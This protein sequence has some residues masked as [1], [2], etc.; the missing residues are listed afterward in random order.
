LT[1][2]A[3]HFANFVW[4]QENLDLREPVSLQRS[5]FSKINYNSLFKP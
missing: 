3:Q 4:T 1:D 5:A 2:L